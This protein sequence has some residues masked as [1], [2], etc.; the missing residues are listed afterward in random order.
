MIF[1]RRPERYRR[2]LIIEDEP[3]VAFDNEHALA[4]AGHEVVAT[5]DTL[6][7]AV[8]ALDAGAIDLVLADISLADDAHGGV[9]LARRAH[10]LGVPVLFVTGSPLPEEARPLALGI[11]AKPYTADQLRAAIEALEHGRRKP[12]GLTLF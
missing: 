3:L 5:V 12:R 11:L 6:A 10:G 9:K 4:D 8:A 1:A 7:D 2:L